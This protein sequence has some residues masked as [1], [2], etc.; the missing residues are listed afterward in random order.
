MKMIRQLLMMTFAVLAFGAC[1]NDDVLSDGGD[2]GGGVD[3]N[4]ES[5]VSLALARPVGGTR[6]LHDPNQDNGDAPESVMNSVRTIFFN[7]ANLVTKDY[8][9]VGTEQGAAGAAGDAFKVPS[10]STKVLVIVNPTATNLQQTPFNNDTPLATVNAAIEELDVTTTVANLTGGTSSAGNFMMT[11]ARG[12]LETITLHST[13]EAAKASPTALYVDRVVSKVRVYVNLISDNTNVTVENPGW[14]LNVTNKKFFPMSQRLKTT[15]NT[16]TPFDR[17]GLGSYRIDPNYG[18]S[19]NTN[20]IYTIDG[21]DT[22]NADYIA[23]YHYYPSTATPA[24]SVWNATTNITSDAEYCLENT[25]AAE[26]NYHAYTTQVLL[27]ANFYPTLFYLPGDGGSPTGTNSDAENDWLAIG[28]NGFY[29]LETIVLW[30]QEELA[31]KYYHA[32]PSE[33]ITSITT[34]YNAFIAGIGQTPVDI[35]LVPDVGLSESDAITKAAEVA[36]LFNDA[37]LKAAIKANGAAR[38]G[39]VSYYKAGLSYYKIMI[40]HDDSPDYVNALGE[41]GVVRNS[42]YDIEVSKFNNPGYP[43]IPEPD[44]GVPDET[45]EGYLSIKIDINPWTWYRQVEPL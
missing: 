21:T 38:V 43:F 28:T 27:K 35:E 37:T 7:D 17:Y 30:I 42:V 16:P 19:I 12:D 18:A 44:P 41:F 23:N 13:A 33:F 34:A 6:S 5:W 4:G 2:G 31:K 24:P 10:S 8:T 1:S 9:L 22:E 40:K 29:T 20:P 14:V 25:Q 36:V 32:K 15:V 26:G 11:N 45:N 39:N 3:P